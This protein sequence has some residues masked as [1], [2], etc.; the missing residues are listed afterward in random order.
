[1]IKPSTSAPNT[2][3]PNARAGFG[4]GFVLD[5]WYFAALGTALK[6]GKLQRYEILGEPV[7]IGRTL[8]GTAYGLRD[9]CPHR[10]APLSAGRLT[11]DDAGAEAVECPYHGWLFRTDGTC[12]KIPSLVEGQG[13]ELDRIKRRRRPSASFRPRA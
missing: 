10:A 9:I 2:D 6:P 1:M 5:A 11:R 4:Q 8:A 12:S 13:L 3:R 7:L